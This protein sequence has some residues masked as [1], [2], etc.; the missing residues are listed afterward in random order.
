MGLA[1]QYFIWITLFILHLF[2]ERVPKEPFSSPWRNHILTFLYIDQRE[3][4]IIIIAAHVER[5]NSPVAQT[6]TLQGPSRRQSP[7]LACLAPLQPPRFTSWMGLLHTQPP[8][9]LLPL[10]PTR[11]SCSC[12]AAAPP[13]PPPPPSRSPPLPAL[14]RGTVYLS[15]AGTGIASSAFLRPRALL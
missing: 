6:A 15:A 3:Q 5:N 11:K 9:K 14:W 7:V 4:W 8:T 1:S 12:E 2:R 13:P 10:G